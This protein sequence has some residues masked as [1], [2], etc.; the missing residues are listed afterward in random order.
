MTSKQSATKEVSSSVVVVKNTLPELLEWN[1]IDRISPYLDRH[2]IFP[3]LDYF[4]KQIQEVKNNNTNETKEED[5]PANAA[6]LLKDVNEARYQLL[7]PTHMIDYMMDVYNQSNSNSSTSTNTM[8]EE[9]V[10]Q[11][12]QV[13]KNL[14][15]LK[16]QCLPLL[17]GIDTATRVCIQ[18]NHSFF[19]F[20]CR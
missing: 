20:M 19:F 13:L 17:E 10:Q 12:Q 15:S 8:P 16:Q 11:K 3:L 5:S 9:M 7:R 14:E 4:E 1:L 2:M 6:Q 18:Y